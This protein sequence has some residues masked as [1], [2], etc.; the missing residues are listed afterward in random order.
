MVRQALIEFNS[1]YVSTIYP[2][3]ETPGKGKRIESE[4]EW[5]EDK[6]TAY[7][8]LFRNKSSLLAR[9]HRL[10]AVKTWR[11]HSLGQESLKGVCYVKEVTVSGHM[12]GHK[13]FH[14]GKVVG[15][16]VPKN[17]FKMNPCL[18]HLIGGSKN[19][20]VQ[21]YG[22]TRR[23]WK[24]PDRKLIRNFRES[25]V[26]RD[27]LELGFWCSTCSELYHFTPHR[28]H[29]HATR[30]ERVRTKPRSVFR[31]MDWILFKMSIVHFRYNAPQF[32]NVG[33]H[34]LRYEFETDAMVRLP[35][36]VE[37]RNKDLKSLELDIW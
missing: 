25:G 6:R 11:T 5:V 9:V 27:T 15:Q 31:V 14:R 3:N 19:S 13:S 23:C 22:K 36:S 21:Q 18:Q 2:P 8:L 34:R 16:E 26:R 30:H 33:P 24:L 4:R 17:G 32:H 1:Q 20:D 37:T 28:G 7:G 29:G 12:P 35:V 10:E